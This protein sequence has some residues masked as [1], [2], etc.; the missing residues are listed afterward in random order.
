MK[1]GQ[2]K[3]LRER[4]TAEAARVERERALAEARWQ[5][6]CKSRRT[7]VRRWTE[8][9]AEALYAATLSSEDVRCPACGGQVR[10]EGRVLSS[11]VCN[12]C[13]NSYDRNNY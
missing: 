10:T 5:E 2:K 4:A 12:G 11:T 6:A 8:S 7:D 3:K 1:T 13:D 9:E